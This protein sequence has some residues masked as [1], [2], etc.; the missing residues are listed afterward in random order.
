MIHYIGSGSLQSAQVVDNTKKKEECNHLSRAS[1]FKVCKILKVLDNESLINLGTALGL[2]YE[3]LKRMKNLPDDMV[4]AWLN[5]ADNVTQ[6]S[7]I[8]CSTS[9]SIALEA[10]DQGGVASKVKTA[11]KKI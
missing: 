10:I 4:N 9:L 1:H 6:T 8:P 11:N 3:N 7:G 2:F 5:E